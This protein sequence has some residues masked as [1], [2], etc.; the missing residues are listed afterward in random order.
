MGPSGPRFFLYT[1]AIAGKKGA[2]SYWEDLHSSDP[3]P[4]ATLANHLPNGEAGRKG[5]LS[6]LSLWGLNA[7]QTGI[8]DVLQAFFQPKGDLLDHA[9]VWDEPAIPKADS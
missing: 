8:Q 5:S 3:H 2:E 9:A 7:K 4:L 6:G 1:P